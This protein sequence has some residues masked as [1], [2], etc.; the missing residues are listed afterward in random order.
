MTDVDEPT[1]QGRQAHHWVPISKAL[2]AELPSGRPF[3]RLEAMFSLS[4][5]YDQGTPVTVKG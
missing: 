2:A 4:I 3:T 1:T 5:D